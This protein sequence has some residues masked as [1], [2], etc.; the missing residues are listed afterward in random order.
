[1]ARIKPTEIKEGDA[2]TVSTVNSTQ[3]DLRSLTV[4]NANI[5]Q[6]GLNADVIAANAVFDGP[7]AH[8]S[9]VNLQRSALNTSVYPT[10]DIIRDSGGTEKYVTVSSVLGTKS[11]Q[12]IV[13]VSGRVFMD[14]YG[15]RT[16]GDMFCPTVIVELRKSTAVSPTSLTDYSVCEGTRQSF[17]LAW[18]GKIPSGSVDYGATVG[19]Y[20]DTA[21]NTAYVGTG[22]SYDSVG[23]PP[24]LVHDFDLANKAGRSFLYDF[25][26]QTSWLHT[27]STDQNQVHFALFASAEVRNPV[28]P[29]SAYASKGGSGGC[30]QVSYP[31]FE[32][33]F[34]HMNA[35]RVKK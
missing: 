27:P 25:V 22:G 16:F 4:G 7:T 28:A 21:F 29:P 34:T 6:E 17:E 23:A 8:S 15:A 3:S 26:Y 32:M 2:L 19:D 24:E 10:F 35:L 11:E 30:G 13:R 5:R 1:M 20:T 12:V 31:G 33:L 14:D 18:S 9:A